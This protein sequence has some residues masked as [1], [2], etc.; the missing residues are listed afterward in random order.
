MA[1]RTRNG[2]V[3]FDTAVALMIQKQAA[4]A[5][6]HTAFLDQLAKDRQKMMDLEAEIRQIEVRIE[7]KFEVIEAMLLRHEAEL[8]RLTEAVREKIGFKRQ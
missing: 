6:Q 3:N 2:R 5:A 4:L 7:K 1:T 8:K